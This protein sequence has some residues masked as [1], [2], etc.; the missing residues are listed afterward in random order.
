MWKIHMEKSHA[1]REPPGRRGRKVKDQSVKFYSS[2]A[3]STPGRPESSGASA[4]ESGAGRGSHT[5][6]HS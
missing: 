2:R 1:K 6:I 4:R 5:H 3:Y